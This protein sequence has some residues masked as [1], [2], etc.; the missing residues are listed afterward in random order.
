MS[1][2]DRVNENA[3]DWCDAQQISM[4]RLIISRSVGNAIK[5]VDIT[6]PEYNHGSC[7]QKKSHVEGRFKLNHFCHFCYANGIEHPHSERSCHRKKSNQSNGYKSNHR[8][9]KQDYRHRNSRPHDN[10]H[11]YRNDSKN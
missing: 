2:I 1:T 6:C 4:D 9:S 5:L 7:H 10:A 8:Q 3:Y 11:E